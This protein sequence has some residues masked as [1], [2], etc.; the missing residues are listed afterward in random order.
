MSDHA[1]YQMGFGPV[2]QHGTCTA[3]AERD[4]EIFRL[5]CHISEQEKRV[6]EL[7]DE[8][9]ASRTANRELE[10]VLAQKDLV[11]RE[12]EGRCRT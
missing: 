8:L 4:A 11:I 6:H 12:L 5:Q 7:Q 10:S 2:H 1:A 9:S 3:C